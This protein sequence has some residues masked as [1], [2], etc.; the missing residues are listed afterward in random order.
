L[1]LVL[2]AAA[3]SAG[4][5][6]RCDAYTRIGFSFGGVHIAG[7]F[8]E[9]R[10]GETAVR[11]QAGYMIHAL[12]LN[13]SVLRYFETGNIAPYAGIGLMKH[14]RNMS[15]AGE[16]LLCMPLGADLGL[17][18]RQHLGAE[19]VPAVPCSLLKDRTDFRERAVEYVFPLPSLLYKYAME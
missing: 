15:L 16:S 8:V 4:R 1:A 6:A 13:L 3:V 17:S 19:L 5:G 12:S 7:V 11:V 10:A 2:S 18:E 9:Q 14:I